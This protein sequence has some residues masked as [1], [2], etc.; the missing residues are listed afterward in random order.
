[1]RK[2]IIMRSVSQILSYVSLY[3]NRNKVLAL[4]L[5]SDVQNYISSHIK[6]LN[7]TLLV[8]IMYFCTFLEKWG[9]GQ[10]SLGTGS[11]TDISQQILYIYEIASFVLTIILIIKLHPL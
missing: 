6:Y 7:F 5:I 2:I 8:D 11:G 1:M 10:Q 3:D 9:I 4:V